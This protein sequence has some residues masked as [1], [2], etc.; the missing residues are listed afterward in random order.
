MALVSLQELGERLLSLSVLHCRRVQL[1]IGH[2]RPAEG[3]RGSLT[4]AG[5]LALAF[6]AFRTVRKKF[7]LLINYP[8]YGIFLWQH[9]LIKTFFFLLEIHSRIFTKEQL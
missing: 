9:K 8:V 1:E 3:P 6:P 2:L 4:C 7:L 5:A